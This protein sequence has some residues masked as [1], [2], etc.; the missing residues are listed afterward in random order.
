[1]KKNS[2][3]CPKCGSIMFQIMPVFRTDKPL[4]SQEK[5]QAFTN[6]KHCLHC[7]KDADMDEQLYGKELKGES[8]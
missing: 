6:R 7:E 2:N 8:L 1:M 5:I 3:N 4:P